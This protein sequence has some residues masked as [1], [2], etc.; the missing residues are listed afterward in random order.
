MQWRNTA[1]KNMAAIFFI[2]AIYFREGKKKLKFEMK[3]K[4]LCVELL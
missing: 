2:F 1:M 3:R 4:N